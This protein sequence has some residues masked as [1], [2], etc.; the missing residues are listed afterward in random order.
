VREDRWVSYFDLAELGFVNPSTG[1]AFSR[2]HLIDM[3]RRGDWP[4]A[5]QV[6]ANRIAWRMS[7]L[8]PRDAALPPARSLM[9]EPDPR[10]AAIGRRAGRP[11]QPGSERKA[12]PAN[13]GRGRGG[14][15]AD[16]A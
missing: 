5:T 1:K 3:M 10:R 7:Q 12:H 8:L 9:G 16:A 11:R 13:R 2:K 14:G 4:P 6:S 15:A